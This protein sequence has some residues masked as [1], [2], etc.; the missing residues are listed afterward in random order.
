[1]IRRNLNN[2][3]WGFHMKKR[4]LLIYAL[5]ATIQVWASAIILKPG[6][7]HSISF[8]E[9]EPSLEKRTIVEFTAR[10][11]RPQ[12]IGG[13]WFMKIS[14]NQKVIGNEIFPP[15]SQV[16]RLVNREAV[17]FHGSGL[18]Y[19]KGGIWNVVSYPTDEPIEAI[20]V[21][22]DYNS[23]Y[24]YALDLTDSLTKGENELLITNNAPTPGKNEKSHVPFLLHIGEIKVYTKDVTEL[25]NPIERSFDSIRS[26]PNMALAVGGGEQSIDAVNF[27]PRSGWKRAIRFRARLAYG[28]SGHAS[29]LQIIVND[30]MVSSETSDRQSRLLNRGLNY[31][32]SAATT[33]NDQGRLT[34]MH[35]SK[36]GLPADK[37]NS[38]ETRQVN[39]YYL[40]CDDLLKDIDNKLTFRN[41]AQYDYFV[42]R[43]GF[44]DGNPF[45]LVHQ[46]ELGYVPD[47]CT[48]LSPA[49]QIETRQFVDS[50]T[51]KKCEDY[52]LTIAPDGGLQIQTGIQKYF[53]ESFFSYPEGGANGFFCAGAEKIKTE[54]SWQGT[55]GTTNDGFKIDFSGKFYKITRT[56]KCNPQT[57][58]VSDCIENISGAPLGMRTG[59]NVFLDTRAENIR[60]NGSPLYQQMLSSHNNPNANSSI[61][62]AF[63]DNGLGLALE[64]DL[65]R[66]QCSYQATP[67]MGK[68]ETAHLGFDA[69]KKYI[70][71]WGLYMTPSTDYFDFVN[72]VRRAWLVNLTTIPGPMLWW[73]SFDGELFQIRAKNY[74]ADSAVGW[75]WF[76]AAQNPDDDFTIDKAM[77]SFIEW[78]NNNRKF[79][80]DCKYLLQFQTTFSWR[81]REGK[82]DPLADSAIVDQDGNHPVYARARV[83]ANPK[84][85][86]EGGELG[87]YHVY[88]YPMIGNRYY[89]Y[90]MEVAKKAMDAGFSGMYFDTPNN[91]AMHYGRFTYDRWDG[92][93]VDLD[94]KGNIIRKYGDCCLLSAGARYNIYK[95]IV[96]RNGI[97]ILNSPPLIKRLQQ[98]EGPVVRFSEGDRVD[99]LAQMHFTTPVM[100]GQ[101]GPHGKALYGRRETWKTEEDLMDDMIWKIQNGILY[102]PY[103]VPRK[104]HE[105]P[106]EWP[107]RDMFPSTILD[108][109]AGWIRAKERIITVNSGKFRWD[110]PVDQVTCRSY[111]INGRMVSEKVIKPES[112]GQF[113]V[114]VP[115]HGMSILIR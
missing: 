38:A 21:P 83:G 15:G 71:E 90:I 82:P 76:N 93:T 62:W 87:Q 50:S 30:Q 61:F 29:D 9:I 4:L 64:D 101:H 45:L 10:F 23:L 46:L 68:V 32:G 79:V 75:T 41:L 66:L 109:H 81:N 12:K 13:E 59:I 7:S 8:N 65:L 60:K 95:Y 25:S 78:K 24:R 85:T 108:I 40:D 54:N 114:T 55:V 14:L 51:E 63:K 89:E 49:R 34:V 3:S 115:S 28:G 27:P 6:Q 88:R 97:V 99:R 18:D 44:K 69:G 86:Y 39:W 37:S 47:A 104:T 67:F 72:A 22:E 42:K 53:V 80:P 111:G 96:E 70:L 36:W 11:E 94:D 19:T 26:Y 73:D 74:G 98:M 110:E 17:S 31:L 56:V 1:M 102:Y 58:R 57:I 103:Y 106:H 2:E 20:Y 100:L 77:E 48:T 43:R 107:T 113:M 33:L 84:S 5:A 35:G 92:Y 16:M 112:D 52:T 91:S 105:N